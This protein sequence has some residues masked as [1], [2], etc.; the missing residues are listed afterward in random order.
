MKALWYDETIVEEE[1]E[2]IDEDFI[3][4]AKEEKDCLNVIYE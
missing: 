3:I 1:D 4:K 2:I